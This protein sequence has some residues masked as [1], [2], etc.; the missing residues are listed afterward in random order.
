ME[1]RKIIVATRKSLL[2]VTQTG[3]TVDAL[4]KANPGVDFEL[5]P[6]TSTGDRITDKPL[7]RIG[8]QG[9]FVK[10]LETA[11]SEKK[12]DIA[13]HSLKDVPS[14]QPEGLVLAGFPARENPFDVLMSAGG[15][16]LKDLPEGAKI[17][18]SSPRRLIQMKG[19]RPDFVFSDLRG[20]LDTRLRKLNEGQYDAILVAAAGMRR[21]GLPFTESQVLSPE[22]CLPAIGQG[23]IAIECREDDAQARAIASSISDPATEAA[24]KAERAFMRRIG[25]GCSAPVAAY[26]VISGNQITLTAMIGDLKSGLM[27]RSRLSLA[28][29]QYEQAGLRLA[30]EMLRSF[31]QAQRPQ[32]AN[33]KDS[34]QEF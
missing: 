2:A 7:S 19:A 30:E 3:Q 34:A 20:N 1:K 14:A 25:A 22:I 5:H 33:F 13:V 9:V 24:V 17:G 26:G 21:L 27:V 10:E 23:A 12:A 18:T 32:G 28:A 15:K 4:R 31:R 8:G 16:Q 6:V 11:L 29:D